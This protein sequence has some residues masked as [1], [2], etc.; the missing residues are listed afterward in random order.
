M[1]LLPFYIA[2]FSNDSDGNSP[3]QHPVHPSLTLLTLAS[4]ISTLLFLSR[5]NRMA[6][7]IGALAPGLGEHMVRLGLVAR[8]YEN[9][10]ETGNP[11]YFLL[12]AH[13]HKHTHIPM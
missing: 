11:R 8:D 4:S 2:S 5:F 12:G 9:Q 6:T 10:G 3:F 7:Y 1:T 13:T